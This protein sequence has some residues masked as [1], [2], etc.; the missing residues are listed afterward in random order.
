MPRSRSLSGVHVVGQGHGHAD[1]QRQQAAQIAGAA[2]VIL[3]PLPLGLFAAI[4][5][6]Q[7]LR[8][9]LVA[10]HR[11]LQGGA[12]RLAVGPGLVLVDLVAGIIVGHDH[13]RFPKLGLLQ[14]RVH[15]RIDDPFTGGPLPCRERAAFDSR[16]R[17][18]TPSSPQTARLVEAPPPLRST[19]DPCNAAFGSA[20]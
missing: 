20:P 8:T 5:S 1:G 4:L 6:L 2:I 3:Q 11:P 12:G 15:W 7:G 10:G 18:G 16:S 14:A 9:R 19:T 13:R 17:S